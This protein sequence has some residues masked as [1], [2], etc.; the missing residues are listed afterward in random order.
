MWTL[1]NSGD[2][3]GGV[4]S[5]HVETLEALIA[6]VGALKE[7]KSHP[8]QDGA[9]IAR[10]SYHLTV[11]RIFVGAYSYQGAKDGCTVAC[12]LMA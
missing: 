11:F 7:V 12:T 5:I 10:Y 3:T 2:A 8:P 4:I 1:L 6:E 9:P